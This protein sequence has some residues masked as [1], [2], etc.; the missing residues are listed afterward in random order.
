MQRGVGIVRN[1]RGLDEWIKGGKDGGVMRDEAEEMLIK[2]A[3][4][5]QTSEFWLTSRHFV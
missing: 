2:L 1:A 5:M 4:R 3:G